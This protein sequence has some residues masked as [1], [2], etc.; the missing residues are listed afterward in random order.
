MSLVRTVLDNY[1]PISILPIFSKI[2]EKVVHD[3]FM[4]YLESNGLLS[5]HQFG[6]RKNRST[7]LAVTYFIDQIRKE[8]DDGKLTGAIFIDTISHPGLLGKLP[9]YGTEYIWY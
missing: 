5:K 4:Q 9:S 1:G 7:E 8:A 3:Q 6:F 2:L